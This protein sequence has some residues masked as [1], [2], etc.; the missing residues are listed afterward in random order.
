MP[1]AAKNGCPYTR[2]RFLDSDNPLFSS[3]NWS[4]G[5]GAAEGSKGVT[6][7]YRPWKRGGRFSRKAVMPSRKSS[8]RPM[9]ASLRA[10]ASNWAGSSC[11]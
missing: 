3:S 1:R 7:D 4:R 9:S 11:S 5:E 10:S 6:A 2:R 8:V